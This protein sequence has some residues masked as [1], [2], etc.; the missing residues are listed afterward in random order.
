[1]ILL[2]PANIPESCHNVDGI[3]ICFGH[4]LICSSC[5]SFSLKVKLSKLS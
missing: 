2:K 1:M 5:I 4:S 3:K